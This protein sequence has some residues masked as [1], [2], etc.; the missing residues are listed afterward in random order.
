MRGDLLM[1]KARKRLLYLLLMFAIGLLALPAGAASTYAAVDED[2]P[3][4]G[5]YE[6]KTDV[7]QIDKSKSKN[8]FKI[9]RAADGTV[10]YETEEE[11]GRAVAFAIKRRDA[12]VRVDLVKEMSYY[13]VYDEAI[14]HTRYPNEGDYIRRHTGGRSISRSTFGP[15]YYIKYTFI[16]DTYNYHT[17]RSQEEYMNT[18]VPRILSDIDIN[19]MS[20]GTDYDK[21]KAIYD[22]ICQNITYDYDNLEDDSYKLKYSAYA[23]LHDKKAV[24]QGYANLLYRMLLEAGVDC[25]IIT[26]TGNGGG[27]AWNIVK[28]GSKWYNVDVTWDAGKRTYSYFLK[29]N[30]N[31]DD[32]T[33]DGEFTTSEFNSAYPMSTSDYS[34]SGSNG[35]CY[36]V[37]SLVENKSATCQEDGHEKYK[38]TECNNVYYTN[39]SFATGEHS[40]TKYKYIDSSQH[41]QVCAHCDK[42]NSRAA[43]SWNSGVVT[44]EPTTSREGVRTYTCTVCNG[45]KTES[46]PRLMNYTDISFGT[47]PYSDTKSLS[48]SSKD[49]NGV[50]GNHARGYKYTGAKNETINIEVEDQDIDIVIYLLK[51]NGEQIKKVDSSGTNGT[52]QTEYTFPEDGTLYIQVESYRNNGSGTFTI[53]VSRPLQSISLN[54]SLITLGSNDSETLSVSYS[55]ENTTDSKSVTWSSNNTS[56]ATVSNTGEVRSVSNG[57]ATITATV[58][59]KSAKCTVTVKAIDKPK[60]GGGTPTTGGNTGTTPTTGGRTD[61]VSSITD[62]PQPVKIT[63]KVLNK[64]PVNKKMP[65][66]KASIIST[67]AFTKKKK[68]VIKFPK[69]KNAKNYIIAFKR[70][71]DKKWNYYTTG[72]KTKYS[73]NKLKPKSLLQ[74]KVASFDG[75]ARSKWS[76]TNRRY[77][78]AIKGI[79]KSGKKKIIIS[80]KPLKGATN[81]RIFYSTKKSMKGQKSITVPAKKNVT[82]NK[83]KSGKKYYVRFRP[84]KNYKGKLYQGVLAKKRVVR[85]K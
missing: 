55:P 79:V 34:T 62:K 10:Y 47:N 72:K 18:E 56:V 78:T 48:T 84:L 21:V 68:M 46:I 52:V 65:V 27:H 16:N 59:G 37:Y 3:T 29:S 17:N 8:L 80:F 58:A 35:L 61:N 28:L 77:F 71:G 14:K 82:I 26:G 9:Q 66:I 63:E 51:E 39:L 76:N 67:T 42:E 32:H 4:G 6:E 53:R 7:H 75:K 23:A 60:T 36:H 13:T 81:Y 11:A 33:R 50:S 19:I 40:Y 22:W 25:R 73:I 2:L 54:K 69:V 44:T 64:F 41:A 74:F 31:F 12:S 15:P 45:T 49:G 43:H 30:A 70:I 85:V 83:L 38:C 24:C 20:K 5:V 1:T 57:T